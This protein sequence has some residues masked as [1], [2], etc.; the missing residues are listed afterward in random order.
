VTKL[1]RAAAEFFFP[2]LF[3]NPR[4]EIAREPRIRGFAAFLLVAQAEAYATKRLLLF[5]LRRRHYCGF[6]LF[7]DGSGCGYA[8]AFFEAQQSHALS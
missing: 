7:E 3:L 4:N 6:F 1:G 5:W 8:V 2:A